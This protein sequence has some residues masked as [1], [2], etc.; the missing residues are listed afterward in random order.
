MPLDGTYEPSTQ[1]WVRD[2]VAAY[3][4]SGGVEG[5]TFRGMPVVVL[6][7]RGARSG[8]LRKTPVM[9]VER[10]GKY[11]VVASQG[12][13]PTHPQ[14]YHNLSADPRVELQDGPR[15]QDMVARQVTGDEKLAWWVLAVQA[16]PDYAEYQEKT[17]RDIPVLVL[18]PVPDG[19]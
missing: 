11:A 1:K 12:G 13:A 16:Y 2:Q 6:T 7:T 9:R 18:E 14:W 10:E 17:D 8:V 4:E 3:E 19:H 15:R 5:T